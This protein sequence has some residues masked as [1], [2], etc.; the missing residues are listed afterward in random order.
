MSAYIRNVVVPGLWFGFKSG[1]LDIYYLFTFQWRKLA[2]SVAKSGDQMSNEKLTPWPE[3]IKYD[4]SDQYVWVSQNPITTVAILKHERARADAAMER[5][6]LAVDA[7]EQS[8]HQCRANGDDDHIGG[9][10]ET[11]LAAI[12]MP[13]ERA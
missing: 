2:G 13:K 9:P 5:L 7:M 11:A 1:L 12:D 4:L 8:L 10:L 3:P 6:K